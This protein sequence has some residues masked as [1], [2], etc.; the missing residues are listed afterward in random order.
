MH[1]C[2]AH[3]FEVLILHKLAVLPGNSILLCRELLL[4]LLLDMSDDFDKLALLKLLDCVFISCW[5]VALCK[6]VSDRVLSSEFET[7]VI[8]LAVELMGRE[9]LLV[10]LS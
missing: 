5:L 10:E 6:P 1:I 3:E 9:V 4:R 8:G 7:P 2:R